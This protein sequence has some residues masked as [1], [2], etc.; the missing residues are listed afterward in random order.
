MF[1]HPGGGVNMK[2]ET[3]TIN[4]NFIAYVSVKYRLFK[5]YNAFLYAAKGNALVHSWLKSDLNY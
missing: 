2:F 4:C 3:E 5:R 1:K